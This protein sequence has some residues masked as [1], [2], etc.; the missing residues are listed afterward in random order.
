MNIDIDK[1]EVNSD[2]DL[3]SKEELKDQSKVQ[4][5]NG[6]K[7]IIKNLSLT[8]DAWNFIEKPLLELYIQLVKKIILLYVIK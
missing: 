5:K 1:T 3:V 2:L 6:T 8:K 4:L 7:N